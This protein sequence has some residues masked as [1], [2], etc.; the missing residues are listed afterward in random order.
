MAAGAGRWRWLGT[1]WFLAAVAVLAVND[2]LL[3]AR[4]GGW[5]TGKLSDVAGLAVVAV[6]AAVIVGPRAGT[7]MAGIGF[8]ALKTV[9]GVAERVAPILGGVT[10]RDATDL[11]AL[12]VLVPVW[13]A[14]HRSDR[15]PRP[16]PQPASDRPSSAWPRL[17]ALSATILPI[18]GATFAM[19]ATTAT[20]CAPRPAVDRIVVDHGV[21][22][23]E[24]TRGWGSSQW[25]RMSDDGRTWVKATQPPAGTTPSDPGSNPYDAKPT[26]PLRSCSPD[27]T[28]F[29][30]RDQRV[31]ER[32]SASG[33]SVDEFTLT[34]AQFD[35]IS[36][37]C[38]GTHRGVL[39]S[40]AAPTED[41]QPAVASLGAHG[42]IV[43]QPDGHWIRVGVLGAHP[44]APVPPTAARLAPIAFGPLLV[45]AIWLFGRRRWPAWRA[46]IGVALVGWF[47]S[48]LV[49]AAGAIV[50]NA[51]ATS[52]S[53]ALSAVGCGVTLVASVLV[54]RS[55]RFAPR[56]WPPPWMLPPPPQPPAP[57]TF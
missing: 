30:L 49:G 34:D 52:G 47:G 40:V 13:V 5:W 24:V 55:R 9:P 23:A 36:T 11:Q 17:A 54:G 31:V 42:V 26:G 48:I 57:G 2:H 8:V 15:R 43:R 28:C 18:F 51:D 38:D 29:R 1:W 21:V 46:A 19:V 22:Y 44:P 53:L 45:G 6:I 33:D 27:G 25:A 7:A 16:A 4:F 14:L 3:K 56:P 39:T 50:A 10:A 37:G 12:V 20:S 32:T 35:A 41:G